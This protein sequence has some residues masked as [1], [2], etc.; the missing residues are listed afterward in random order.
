M[1]KAYKESFEKMQ[2]WHDGTRK[3]NVGAMGDGKLKLSYKVCKDKGFEKEAAI[4]KAEA[5]KRGIVLGS[6]FTHAEFMELI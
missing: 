5:D 1:T 6:F 2:K 3:Q 4:L